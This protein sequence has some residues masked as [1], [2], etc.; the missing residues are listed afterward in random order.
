MNPIR[1]SALAIAA[2]CGVV[3]VAPVV[4]AAPLTVSDASDSTATGAVPPALTPTGTAGAECPPPTT[5][6]PTDPTVTTTTVPESTTTTTTTTT[7]TVPA[8]PAGLVTPADPASPITVPPTSTP[9]DPC[10]TTTTTTVPV[11]TDTTPTTTIDPSIPTTVAPPSSE[12]PPP[13]DTAPVPTTAVA[14]IPA[15]TVPAE[16]PATET[17]TTIAEATASATAEPQAVGEVAPVDGS[18]ANLPLPPLN[19]SWTSQG[20][21]RFVLPSIP[22]S[23]ALQPGRTPAGERVVLAENVDV[24]LATIR[25]LES[26]NRYDIG[27]NKAQAS[28]AYQYIPRTWNN[29][30]GYA[31]AYLAPPEVQDE[32]ARSDVERFL[33]MYGGN[34]AMVPV[35]WYYPRA[36]VEPLWMDRVPNPA[37]GNRLT[38]RQYQTLWLEKLDANAST[39]LGTYVAT[40][41]APAALSV[42]SEIPTPTTTVPVDPAA[43]DAAA[44]AP[45]TVAPTTVRQP[46]PPTT[47]PP[48]TVPPTT[49]PATVPPTPVAAIPGAPATD[50]ATETSTTVAPTTTI[51]V[52]RIVSDEITVSEPTMELATRSVPPGYESTGNEGPARTI[53]FPVLGPVAYADG[54]M[55]SRDG[56]RRRHEGTDIVGVQMQPILAAVDGEITRLQTESIGIRGVA[57][58][59]RDSDG[60]RYNYFHDNNDTPGTDDGQASD[61]FRLA[62]G[63]AVGSQVVAGQI[64][65]YMGDSGNA[66]DSVTHLHFEFRNPDGFA[67]PSYWSLKAAEAR[68]A[69]TIGIGPWSTPV[70]VRAGRRRAP[71]TVPRRP[72]THW[73]L[74]TGEPA[75]TDGSLVERPIEHTVV[76]PLF[77]EGQWVIDSDGRVTATGDAALILPRRDLQCD[78]GP[79]TPFGTDAAGWREITSGIVDGTVL[80]GADLSRTILAGVVPKPEPPATDPAIPTDPAVPTDAAPTEAAAATPATVAPVTVTPA[81]G[82]ALAPA[83]R[84]P[85]WT[86][87]GL[88][89]TSAGT[90]PAASPLPMTTPS[91]L[92]L[93]DAPAD[94]A[95]VDSANVDPAEVVQTEPIGEP[96][97]FVDTATGETIIVR[98][99]RPLRPDRLIGPR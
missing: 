66:E 81:T 47:V 6:P 3:A 45:T 61:A 96:L 28:G 75:A 56:G 10:D 79:A 62:P 70:L 77:G 89:P 88:W 46:V 2:T 72:R 38:I 14:E 33:T 37:G 76:T 41:E 7:T 26:S 86:S 22:G 54:W 48:T 29:Y 42:V 91:A 20:V 82:V 60:W 98:F 9:V 27:P 16:V 74:R 57:I 52:P 59:I 12:V 44:A 35:M 65:G 36:A 31:E 43:A 73:S 32:R 13:V 67:S 23:S 11:P 99:E 58:T 18:T 51:P 63:L 69:C 25:Q 53:V 85:T 64:I 55:D 71:A 80:E 19:P 30:G 21:P 84:I 8:P 97:A 94:P 95:D 93:V 68:Q 87:G 34:V 4:D 78:P 50:P 15:V 92:S 24:I 90:A 40:P 83:T 5:V 49:V 1:R 39:L 17:T